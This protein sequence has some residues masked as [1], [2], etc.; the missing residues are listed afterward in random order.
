M[1]P[2]PALTLGPRLHEPRSEACSRVHL[3][4]SRLERVAPPPALTLGPRINE[5]RFE[6][7]SSFD[8]PKHKKKIEKKK[9]P[10]KN[11]RKNFSKKFSKSQKKIF[12][13]KNFFCSEWPK[14][15]AQSFSQ[16]LT[17][18]PGGGRVCLS[19][20]GTEPIFIF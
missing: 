10:K 2:P 20:F 8:G 15:S 5:S 14:T 6:A 18:V 4:P 17:K 19:V 13:Q 9:F 1:A 7:C 16:H 11:F 3:G 12:N